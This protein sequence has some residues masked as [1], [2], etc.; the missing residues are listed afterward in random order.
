MRAT[1]SFTLPEEREEFEL[2]SKAGHLDYV[3]GELDNFLRGKIKYGQHSAE[4][5]AIYQEVR[6]KLWELR[7]DE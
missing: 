4:V 7:N 1:L 6:D 2:A 3:I 5:E